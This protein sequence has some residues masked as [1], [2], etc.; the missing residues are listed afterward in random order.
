MTVPFHQPF[1]CPVLIGRTSDFARLQLSLEQVKSGK[2]QVA[3]LCGEAGIGKSRLITELKTE[4]CSQLL[5]CGPLLPL[6]SLA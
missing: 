2:G 4:A 5:P 3:L 1:V 6:R